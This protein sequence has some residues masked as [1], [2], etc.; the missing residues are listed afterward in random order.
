[1]FKHHQENT[2]LP[3]ILTS[4]AAVEANNELQTSKVNIQSHV[5]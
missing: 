4:P 5:G 1:M 3:K 2:G